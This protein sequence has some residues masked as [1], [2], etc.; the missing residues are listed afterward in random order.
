MYTVKA[1]TGELDMSPDG[2]KGWVFVSIHETGSAKYIR[3]S[4]WQARDFGMALVQY[5]AS[6]RPLGIAYELT[7]S[8]ETFAEGNPRAQG[9]R[10]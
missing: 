10:P 5:A 4:P 8:S 3:I 7:T 1:D 9:R 2:D 6:C